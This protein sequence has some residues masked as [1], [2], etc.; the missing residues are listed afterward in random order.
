MSEQDKGR[1]SREEVRHMAALSR[2]AVTAEEE[3]VFA[4]QFG[5]ILDHM[6]ILSR[7]DTEGVEPLY[8]PA[9]H[10]EETRADEAHNV[11]E[12]AQILANAPATDGEYFIV[13]RI[14]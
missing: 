12:R 8:S 3:R 7:V 9:T 2:L 6:D 1:V 5:Q 14:V 13:P 4:R 10:A 11:R